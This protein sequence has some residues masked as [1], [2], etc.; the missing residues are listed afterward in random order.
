MSA[1]LFVL[2]AL[3][4]ISALLASVMMQAWR[5]ID[6]QPHVLAWAAAHSAAALQWMCL[7]ADRM[8]FQSGGEFWILANALGIFVLSALLV[9]YRLR[10]GLIVPMPMLIGVGLVVEG[11]VVWFT[12]VAPNLGISAAI[13]P[14]YASVILALCGHAV[15][16]RGHPI[17][18]AEWGSVIVLVVFAL[19]EFA[20]GA[21]ATGAGA[22]DTLAALDIYA[23]LHYLTLPAAY[24]GIGIFS[25]FLIATDLAEQM[26]NLAITDPL[27]GVLN[28]RGFLDAAL[29]SISHAQRTSAPLTLVMA[30]IDQFKRLNDTY[31]HAT[32]DK[33]LRMFSAHLETALRR[34]D[35]VG[36]MGGE[37]FALVLTDT[38]VEEGRDVA[39]RLCRSLERAVVEAGHARI[40]FTASFGVARFSSEDGDLN[41]V[42]E[43]ADRALYQAKETGRNRV[44][45]AQD[46]ASEADFAA[47]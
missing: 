4:L 32:G 33:A 7:L 17:L 40:R 31:G 46:D 30:D 8:L 44:C 14:L 26:K 18:P 29:R 1:V 5:W 35:L 22:A 15:L 43:R 10:S 13:M 19:V 24:A 36:R 9:G 45:V 12:A 25:V 41:D 39:E 34:S 11:A 2:V 47:A 38:G 16:S 21:V 37:E 20:A 3:G 42:L 28:R 23:A 6:R 27:T